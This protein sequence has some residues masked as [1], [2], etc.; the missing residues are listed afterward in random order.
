M[1]GNPRFNHTL[2]TETRSED[3][4]VSSLV[5]RTPTSSFPTV[6]TR[7]MPCSLGKKCNLRTP[8]CSES[9]VRGVGHQLIK[10]HQ[11]K[12]CQYRTPARQRYRVECEISPPCSRAFCAHTTPLPIECPIRN[13]ARFPSWS[14]RGKSTYLDG[15]LLT[16]AWRLYTRSTNCYS[17][18]G[19]YLC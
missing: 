4:W 13:T 17:R 11:G 9:Q 6:L 5:V 2:N 19:E 1:V 7:I 10:R 3:P 15:K 18:E 14:I 8:T 16:R 12:H